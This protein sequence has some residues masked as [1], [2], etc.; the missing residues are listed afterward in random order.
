MTT[1][2]EGEDFFARDALARAIYR[3][4]ARRL[5]SFPGVGVRTGK[6]EVAF[7]ARRGFAFAWAPQKYVTSDVPLVISFAL[8]EPLRSERIRSVVH[9]APAIWMH[10]AE[11]RR[12]EDVDPELM[13]WLARAYREARRPVV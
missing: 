9:P 10:H 8:A 7:R 12:E 6:S 5:L 4:I 2:L 1:P 11:L 3:S 13:H